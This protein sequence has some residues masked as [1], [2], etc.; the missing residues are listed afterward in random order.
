[1]VKFKYHSL[2]YKLKFEFLKQNQLLYQKTKRAF[3]RARGLV[4]KDIGVRK[5]YFFQILIF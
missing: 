3:E 1:M 5:N 2:T 4:V